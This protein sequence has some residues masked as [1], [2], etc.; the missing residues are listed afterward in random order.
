MAAITDS[1][2]S[3]SRIKSDHAACGICGYDLR[4]S[5][6]WPFKCPECGSRFGFFGTQGRLGRYR[7]LLVEIGTAS[8]VVSL[9]AGISLAF[10][11][12]DWHTALVVVF[13]AVGFG[14]ALLASRLEPQ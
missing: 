8:L 6:Q 7:R 4:G 14:A 10:Y 12:F 1:R 2:R 5:L 3:L 11:A 13:I 9:V